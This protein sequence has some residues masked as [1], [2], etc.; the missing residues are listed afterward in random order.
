MSTVPLQAS[1][2]IWLTYRHFP[3]KAWNAV[4][5]LVDN[6]SQS[7]LDNRAILDEALEADGDV[8]AV[9]IHFARDDMFSL[10][11]NALGMDLDDLQRAV[12]LAAP[13]PD[14]SGRSEF[15]MG[16]KTSCCWLGDTWKLITKKLGSTVEYTVNID[17]KTIAASDAHEI[18]VIEKEAPADEHYTRVE[19]TDLHRRLPGRTLGAVRKY[20]AE[21]FRHD[22]A[23]GTMVLEWDGARLIPE[24]IEPL[25]TEDRVADG[26]VTVRVW[27]QDIEFEVSG[28]TVR[29]WICL[30][31]NGSRSKAGFDLYRRGRVI[32]GRPL[33]YRP[34]TI[35]GEQR[36][37]LINQRLY[38]Q[39]HL[40]DFPVNH[41]KD[42]FLW[43]GLEDDLQQKLKEVCADYV[44]FARNFRSRAA[45][46]AVADAVIHAANDE[47]AN[48]LTEEQMLDRLTIAEVSHEAPETDE[49]ILE[50]KADLLRSQKIDARI[51]EIGRYTFR[52]FHPEDMSPTE[53][54]FFR[55]SSQP[56]MIDIF[57][58]DNHPYVL[59]ITDESDY[60]MYV[61]MCVVD[62][63]T[64]HFMIHR[65]GEIAPA[66]PAM[67]KDNLLRGFNV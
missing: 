13:P 44:E 19:V 40:D 4:G 52:I 11:D 39:F 61:R 50:A 47:I 66:L 55:I 6:S 32:L 8:F 27:R 64:E 10:S 28:K 63:I 42:D 49:A 12:Q 21:M 41:L 20:L 56:D 36:N 37:D 5:E 43:E 48:E 33:G 30:L 38:G 15:G 18:A 22:I 31:K 25:V 60:L 14:R 24:V 3:Y 34:Q 57:L 62:A 58:N 2:R 46:Q 23:D 54:Y 65:G 53:A 1:N 29:G 9:R 59:A 26:H 17:V 45:G 7:Y 51:V 35:F 67:I 16:M